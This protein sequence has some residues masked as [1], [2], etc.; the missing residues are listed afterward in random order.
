MS[1]LKIGDKILLVAHKDTVNTS[2]VSV[3]DVGLVEECDHGGMLLVK[4]NDYR[5]WVDPDQVIPY[6]AR[7]KYKTY[8]VFTHDWIFEKQKQFLTNEE[9]E[10]L[11]KEYDSEDYMLV[12]L[13]PV[14]ELQINKEIVRL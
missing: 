5:G 11:L 12:E 10:E 6:D 2:Y 8:G 3:G 14:A 4:F 13:K 7:R 9:A 1:E